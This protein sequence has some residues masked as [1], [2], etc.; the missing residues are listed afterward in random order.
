MAWENTNVLK[1]HTE[2]SQIIHKDINTSCRVL[3]Q[4]KN[5]LFIKGYTRL[6]F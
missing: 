5:F 2:Y 4:N 1:T 6:S 3:L